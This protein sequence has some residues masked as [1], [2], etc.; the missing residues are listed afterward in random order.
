MGYLF[1][2]IELPS[3]TQI[4]GQL[5]KPALVPWAAKMTSNY[6]QSKL[7]VMED[8]LDRDIIEAVVVEAPKNYRKVAFAAA[9]IGNTVHDMI[10]Q[11]V[12][13]DIEPAK[14]TTAHQQTEVQQA[15]NAFLAWSHHYGATTV[16]SEVIVKGC[17]YA[18][19]CDWIANLMGRVYL[20]DFKTSTDIYEEMRLQVA[21]YRQALPKRYKIEGCG[22]LRLDKA[23][24]VPEWCDTSCTYAQ[25]IRSFNLL[26]L[27][28]WS[29]RPNGELALYK[30]LGGK[31][32]C[33]KILK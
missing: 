29:R 13:S 14:S 24:G 17:G 8:P 30:S 18:G 25:D 28:W 19:T 15:W 9:N 26:C 22:I 31:L 21:A 16:A 1:K 3:V 27:Y 20:I 10:H 23:T 6:I 4:T 5:N 12:T 32:P 7:G 2:G 11:Y 33:V